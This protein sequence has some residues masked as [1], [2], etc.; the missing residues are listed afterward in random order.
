[1][2][3]FRE[4]IIEPILTVKGKLHTVVEIVNVTP[5]GQKFSD[6]SEGCTASFLGSASKPSTVIS[7]KKIANMRN[8]LS[9]FFFRVLLATCCFLLVKVLGLSMSL[10]IVAVCSSKMLRNC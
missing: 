9:P 1:M 7:K 4:H 2:H 5:C 10:K 3:Q 6:V 8:I